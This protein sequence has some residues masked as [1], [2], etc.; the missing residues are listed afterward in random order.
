MPPRCTSHDRTCRG[1][2]AS[3]R[4]QRGCLIYTYLDDLERS[5]GR[6]LHSLTWSDRCRPPNESGKYYYSLLIRFRVSHP[7][8]VFR[9]YPPSV[10]Y[11]FEMSNLVS[12][13]RRGREIYEFCPGCLNNFFR[14][15]KNLNLE[16][17][18]FGILI[19]VHV[20][21]DVSISQ[22]GNNFAKKLEPLEDHW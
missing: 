5:T 10:E 6:S 12:C 11:C 18:R 15:R 22:T 16:T 2:R 4:D 17:T 7:M 14:Y 1:A 9:E 21:S 13:K 20:R 8:G 3:R 19:G